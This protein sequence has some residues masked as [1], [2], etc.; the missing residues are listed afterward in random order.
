MELRYHKE[1]VKF[2]AA[3]DK[4]PKGKVLRLVDHLEKFG[5]TLRMPDS[6][7]VTSGLF[8]LRAR[9]ILEVR[10]LYAFKD[11]KAILLHAFV[12]KTGTIARS[13]IALAL[14]R[15]RALDVL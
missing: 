8:E 3:L 7:P 9:G 6:K 1:V 11:G 5:F 10:I 12:K 14:Q 15:Y 4:I 2:I 13:D